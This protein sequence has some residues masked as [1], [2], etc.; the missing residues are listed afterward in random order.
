MQFEFATANRIIFGP[1]TVKQVP[2]L[3]AQL[4]RC[5]FLVTD[6]E[7][8][9]K[10]LMN[11]LMELDLSVV[12]FLV[13]KEPD[14]NGVLLATRIAK[15]SS[16]QVVIGFGGGSTLDISKV[17]A[18]L[19]NSKGDLLDYLE[20]IGTG[21]KLEMPPIPYIAIPTTSGTGSEVT[22]NAVINVPER[23][24]KTSLRSPFLLPKIAV[25]DPE[26][27]ISLPPAITASTGM[28]ALTQLIEPFVS[29][30]PTP[31][32]DALCR[33]G[34]P[35]VPRSLPE[36]YLNGMNLNARQE[37]ALASLLGGM[38]LANAR[39]GAVHGM[40]NPIG[41]MT[42]APHGAICARLLPLVMEANINALR[43]RQPDS[44]AL[45]RYTEVACILTGN[46]N[47]TADDGI[48]ST[49]ELSQILNIRP[50]REYGMRSEDF[51]ALV[52]QSQ[53]ASSM[54]GNPIAL[55]EA[56]LIKILESAV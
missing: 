31:L 33:D 7:V 48:T 3:A 35:R 50:L 56:E 44:P 34:I 41:G 42:F 40:A 54:R 36:V 30:S 53:K 14:V 23:R 27:T 4:G 49:R 21:R 26:L 46:K 38:A 17:V 29:N 15:E 2:A 39:L 24:I 22:R 5:V 1:G 25:I 6:S 9:C 13:E 12:F 52:E 43:T 37:M 11:V 19:I 55:T 10:S 20:V 18:A 16:S 32:T 47:A 45:A 28:D 8:R 51:P